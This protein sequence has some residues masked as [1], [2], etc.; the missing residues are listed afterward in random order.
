MMKTG[1]IQRLI[2][3]LER[4]FKGLNVKV[5]AVA[6]EDIAITIHKAMSVEARH[7]HTPEHVLGLV[8]L[9]NP[10]QSLAAL[11]H[12]IV[13]YQVDRGFSPEV[14][15]VI[16]PYFH[17]DN[18]EILVNENV[19]SSERFFRLALD[20]FGL[21]PGQALSPASGLNEFISTLVMCSKLESILPEKEL[22]KT[23][24]YIEASIPFRGPDEQGLGPFERLEIRLRQVAQTHAIS[25]TEAEI[26][27]TIQGGVIFANKD[28]EN[29]SEPEPSQFL[30]NTWKL[31]PE[32]NIALRSGDVYSIREYRQALQTM[33]SF[34]VELDPDT[35]LHSYK[36]IPPEE[37]YRRLVEHTHRNVET[38]REYLGTK[39]VATAMLEALAELTGGDAP[40]SLFMGDLEN[41]MEDMKR[42]E[43]YLPKV[44]TPHH[45]DTD[46]AVFRLLDSRR[47]GQSD[48]DAKNAPLAR[49]LYKVLGPEKVQQ[50]RGYAAQMFDGQ[51][52]AK[53]FLSHVD[54]QV[55][56][57]VANAC[58]SMVLTRSEKLAKYVDKTPPQS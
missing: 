47:A 55:T 29:F 3:V 41:D 17:E 28:V 25:M 57:A 38:A 22:L 51:I 31:L 26:V 23:I 7:F 11:F 8:D 13:Y 4:S 20:V 1:T 43:D 16:A 14:Y 32:T 21:L 6:L 15:A 36:G 52:S 5:S 9:S 27:A 35:V 10:I 53:E 50:Y 39:L 45:I 42:M 24:V 48:F 54:V 46:S 37:V 30:E 56:S 18:A 12:D 44:E 33:H 40:M 2:D 58:A 34:L 49:F 19:P